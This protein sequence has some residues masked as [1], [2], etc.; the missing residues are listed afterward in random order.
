[1]CHFNIL[2]FK[3]LADKVTKSKKDEDILF[4]ENFDLTNIETPVDVEK[5]EWMLRDTGYDQELTEYLITGFREGFELGYEG[6]RDECRYAPNLRLRVGNKTELWN[7]MMLEVKDKRF[8]GPFEEPPFEHFIQSPVGLVPKDGGKKTRLI[9]H[10]SYPRNGMVKSV[11]ACIP[12]EKCSVV[13]PDFMD[14]VQ[15][16]M[17]AGKKLQDVK[18]RHVQGIQKLSNQKV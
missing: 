17:K 13:Y 14:A 1:M 2:C 4:Y 16:C 9:F 12:A 11:N 3:F 7:K 5:F 10:L 8:A 6:R 15:L 18:I